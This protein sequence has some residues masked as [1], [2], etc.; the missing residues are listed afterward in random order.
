MPLLL[1]LLVIAF[2]ANL[3]IGAVAIPFDKTLSIL[4]SPSL[5]EG[6][7]AYI[8]LQN[9]LPAA[10]AA[11]LGG[12]GLSCAGLLMQ[13]TFRNPLAGP[14]IMG[15]NSGASL[16]VAVVM[17]CMGGTLS[18][19]GMSIGGEIAVIIAA[20]CGSL[21]IMAVLVGLSF[22]LN[23]DLMLLI[24]GI[25]IGYL[26]SSI[27]LILN[28]SASSEGIQSYVMWGMGS[29][30]NIP[31]YR[32]PPFAILT[33]IGLIIAILL[34]KP[35]DA[36]LLG[37]DYAL[38]MG[39]NVKRIKQLLLLSTGILAAAVT[40]YCGPIAFIGIAVPHIAR[41]LFHT[42]LHRSLMPATLV[43]GALIALL[44]NI[45]CVLPSSGIFEGT[46]S[47]SS[48]P[49]NAVTPLFGVPVILYVL[50]KRR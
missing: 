29:F 37:N 32:I 4:L 45:I 9:R 7:E 48:L 26:T 1:A 18:M 16:G 25:L 38:S 10:I 2:I 50:I 11:L 14:S 44:C 15:I 40:A 6:P 20:L 49:L 31:L 12:A 47:L 39:V 35:L 23:N 43:M 46:L 30:F 24:A 28:Y 42:D 5:S 21:L 33:F 8:I 27:I 3:F 34:V 19:A 22:I 41:M 17:L 13:T 36:L